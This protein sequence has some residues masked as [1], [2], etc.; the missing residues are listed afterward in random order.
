MWKMTILRRG[1][2]PQWNGGSKE[3]LVTCG[4]KMDHVFKAK[5]H[6]EA[7][8]WLKN[9]SQGLFVMEEWRRGSICMQGKLDVGE[10]SFVAG[11]EE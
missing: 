9:T 3:A 5:T 1:M 6:I 2:G 8:R 10:S 4:G 7:L 11:R